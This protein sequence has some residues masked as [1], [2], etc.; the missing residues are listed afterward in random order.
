MRTFE[1]FVQK[2]VEPA[3]DVVDSYLDLTIGDKLRGHLYHSSSNRRVA[4]GIL[5]EPAP[6]F[7][8]T[9]FEAYL[10]KNSR[11]QGQVG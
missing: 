8:F 11:F 9:V 1:I 6:E 5:S 7:F 10:R 2:F 4:W 3:P